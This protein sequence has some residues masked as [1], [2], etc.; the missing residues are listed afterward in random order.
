MAN[1]PTLKHDGDD[2]IKN[3]V[4]QIDQL[5]PQPADSALSAWQCIR[6]NPKVCLWAIWANIGSIMIGYENLALSVC[7][8]MPAFQM[9]FAS[10]IN[11][12][13]LIP[14]HWQSLWN[15][16]FNVMTIVGS[17]AAG[18]IQDWLGRRAVFLT[19]ILVASAGIAIAFVSERPA[20]YLGAKILTGFALGASMVGTQ[21]FVSEITPLPMRGIALSIN[22][23]ALN[24]GLLVAISATFSRIAIID[25]LAFRV[26]FAGAWAFPAALAL[27]LP[28]VPESPYWLVMRGKHEQARKSLV[29]L[30]PFEE[31]IDTRLVNIQH[32]VELERRQQAEAGL[33]FEC[34]KGSNLRRTLIT[35]ICFYMSFTVGSVLSA[36]SPYFLNQSG[37]SSN[38]VLMITQIG[39]SMGVLSSI[40][41]LFLMM[42]F[43]HRILMFSGVGICILA[44]LT[45]GIA[46]AMPRT[47]KT[48]T[49]V[50]IALQFSTLSYGPAVGAAMAVAGEVSATR[51][52][53]NSLALGNGF[54]GVAGTFWQAVLPYLFNQDQADLGGNLGWIFFGIAVLHAALLYFFVPGTK[55]RTFKE[56]D[57][58]FEKK[59]PARAFEKFQAQEA[60]A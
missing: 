16:M 29:R 2:L 7:L 9:T 8:A 25:P 37:L 51:L 18:P 44:Y 4:E 33:L 21:T 56:L 19:V 35:L 30:S 40:V 13:L 50:G 14:A 49:V 48:M 39:V 42:K 45:M 20:T 47:T 60:V 41:N 36:N 22:T 34:F 43:N 58:M 38:T 59:L 53:A 3:Q 10:E 15:A 28:F 6:Q 27:G 54:Q 31:D 55:G 12:V 17:I 32:T 57:I 46:G 26:V 23:V 1:L 11:G 52:R 24:L 5:L